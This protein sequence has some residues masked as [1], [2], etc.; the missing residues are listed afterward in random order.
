[1]LRPVDSKIISEIRGEVFGKPKVEIHGIAHITG[2]GI[3]EKLGRIF[4]D[5][6][7]T[8]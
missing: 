6:T 8:W 5:D 1:M 2:G 4:I 7:K 3:P